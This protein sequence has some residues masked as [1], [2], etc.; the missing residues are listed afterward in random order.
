M[1]YGSH[2]TKNPIILCSIISCCF[3]FIWLKILL[4]RV[5]LGWLGFTDVMMHFF[6]AWLLIDY[7][8]S[9]FVMSSFAV[10]FVVTSLFVPIMCIRYITSTNLS[11]ALKISSFLSSSHESPYMSSSWSCWKPLDERVALYLKE[12]IRNGCRLVKE[13]QSRAS[14]IVREKIFH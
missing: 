12:I 13:L 1:C 5:N 3:F 8:I 10:S 9:R 2:W 14:I 11:F 6:V 4:F 7:Y